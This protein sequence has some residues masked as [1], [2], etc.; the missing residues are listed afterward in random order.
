MKIWRR[1]LG[2]VSQ[3]GEV[4]KARTITQTTNMAM[5]EP[6]M[7]VRE[8]GDGAIERRVGVVCVRLRTLGRRGGG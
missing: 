8:A 3:G 5:S 6:V 7:A 1:Q 4:P 2:G